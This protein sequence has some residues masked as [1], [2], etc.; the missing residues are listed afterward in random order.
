MQKNNNGN[1]EE[2]V[3]KFFLPE[4]NIEMTLTKSPSWLLL[5]LAIYFIILLVI[6]LTRY[7]YYYVGGSLFV[8][9]L[10]IIPLSYLHE[11]SHV[12]TLR[13]LNNDNPT[14]HFD[15]MPCCSS[16]KPIP[17]KVF[18]IDLIAPL[19]MIFVFNGLIIYNS[20]NNKPALAFSMILTYLVYTS[21]KDLYWLYLIRKIPTDRM[22]ICYGHEA[23][24]YKIE[25]E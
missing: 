4:D 25:E 14:I 22:V 21:L 9:A 15:S 13:L 18:V 3:S 10:A 6:A 5:L 7:P 11:L 16:Q 20:L 23:I 19:W 17:L 8:L 2:T 12:W 24:V 1:I